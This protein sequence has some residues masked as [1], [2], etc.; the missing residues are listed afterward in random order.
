[1]RVPIFCCQL[2]TTTTAQEHRLSERD[3]SLSPSWFSLFPDYLLKLMLEGEKFD[4]LAIEVKKP[5]AKTSQIVND[6]SK[7]GNILKLML[8]HS[9]L[10]GVPF[11]IVCG[12]VGDGEMVTA[13][14]MTIEQEGRYDLVELA[15]FRGIRCLDDLLRL[16]SII[17]HFQQLKQ[18]GKFGRGQSNEQ[19]HRRGYNGLIPPFFSLASRQ[20]E[21]AYHRSSSN[22]QT[23]T[24]AV[25]ISCHERSNSRKLTKN[26]RKIE[27]TKNNRRSMLQDSAG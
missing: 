12:L 25:T 1:M 6:T 3:P 27:T 18:S 21:D 15:S 11:L 26:N 22:H 9:V 10:L 5:K 24:T 20:A 14:K 23:Q 16:P 7:L 2:A 13:Y 19:N 17:G 4:V 8:G